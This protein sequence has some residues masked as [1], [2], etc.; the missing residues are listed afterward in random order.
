MTAVRRFSRPIGFQDFPDEL[1]PPALRD[2]NPL[3]IVRR[4]N[5][6]ITDA[7]VDRVTA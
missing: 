2:S 7:P 1:L 3:G 4:V 6:A 5:G